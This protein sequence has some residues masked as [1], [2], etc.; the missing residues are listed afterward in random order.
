MIFII[1]PAGKELQSATLRSAGA[2]LG[3]A[4]IAPVLVGG[5][6]GKNLPSAVDTHSPCVSPLIPIIQELRQNEKTEFIHSL[7]LKSV[8]ND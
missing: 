4:P 7:N 8:L 1:L 3:V 2:V 6:K 5:K